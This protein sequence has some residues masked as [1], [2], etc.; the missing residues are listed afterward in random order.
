MDE[1]TLLKTP[2]KTWPGERGV[3]ACEVVIQPTPSLQNRRHAPW[4]HPVGHGT[5]YLDWPPFYS[6]SCY[7]PPI[8][9]GTSA[10]LSVWESDEVSRQCQL[11]QRNGLKGEKTKQSHGL[12]GCSFTGLE[13][14]CQSSVCEGESREGLSTGVPECEVTFCMEWGR[15]VS[16][17]G[18]YILC[19]G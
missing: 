2:L 7:L 8:Q 17:C 15:K 3:Q 18:V 14:R 6:P 1:Q 13:V 4:E 9:V 12:T 16:V 5:M 11:F 19:G 10:W